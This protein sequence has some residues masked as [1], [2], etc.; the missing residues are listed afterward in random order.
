MR[1]VCIAIVLGLFLSTIPVSSAGGIGGHSNGYTLDRKSIPNTVLIDSNSEPYSLQSGNHDVVVVAFIFTTC[2]DVCPLITSNLVAAQ[3]QLEDIDYQFISVTVDP[4]KDTPEALSDY[5]EN[6]GA[7]WPHLTGNISQLEAVWD[8]FQISVLTEEIETEESGSSPEHQEIIS[9]EFPVLITGWDLLTAA[10]DDNGWTVNSSESS[11]GNYITG[12]NGDDA[13]E[14]YS[15]WWQL[16]SWNETTETWQESNFGI[17]Q[18]DS[19]KL[20]FAPNSTND[21]SIPVPETVGD[22]IVI[23]QSS[24]ISDSF[25]LLENQTNAWHL[26][27]GA[28]EN[29]EAPKSQ[30]GHYLT[31]INGISAPED[32]SWWWNLIYWNETTQNWVTSDLGMDSLTEKAHIAWASNSTEVNLIPAPISENH[33]V[34]VVM[35]NEEKTQHKLGIVYPN[36]TTDMLS[37][38]YFN[39]DSISALNHSKYTFHENEFT[40]SIVNDSFVAI[41]G[42]NSEYKLNYWHNMGGY[43]HWMQA[44]ASATEMM[45]DD[46]NRHFAW[47]ADG[48]SSSSLA[49]PTLEENETVI[50]TSTSH[51]AQTFILNG[52][53]KP[54]IVFTG[55]DWNVDYFVEDVVKVA[56]SHSSPSKRENTVPGFT[57]G[58]AIVGLGLAIIASRQEE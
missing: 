43:S 6:F 58:V 41:D 14:D 3:R 31:S 28:L 15:W 45:L 13:P 51:S 32:Y 17:D 44:S 25:T 27:L 11:W 56:N 1:T 22:S 10:A 18:I 33:S 5:K 35:P 53:W 23:V 12:I 38:I 49:D 7:D 26:T 9:T 29:F 24:G 42:Q 37:K 50:Q 40:Y 36:G 52:D 19:G 16:H 30:Y 55:Y 4:A 34:T 21:E 2:Y 46:E 39:T 54:K 48:Q 57:A 47:V 8:D 20:A